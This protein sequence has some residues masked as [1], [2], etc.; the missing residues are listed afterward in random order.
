M[1]SMGW[2]TEAHRAGGACKSAE[3]LLISVGR[4]REHLG[5]GLETTDRVAPALGR[6]RMDAFGIMG[7]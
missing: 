6:D 5:L 2:E 4:D 7:N 3:G 1:R